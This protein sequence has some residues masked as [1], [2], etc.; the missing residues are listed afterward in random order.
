MVLTN[1]SRHWGDKLETLGSLLDKF[2]INKIRLDKYIAQPDRE[3]SKLASIEGVSVSLG[4]EIDEY[5]SQALTGE[6]PLEEPKNKLYNANYYEEQKFVSMSDVIDK[7]F[8]ANLTLW[9]LEDQRR[10][11]SFP[12]DVRLKICD[13]V[14]VVNGLRNNCMDEIN[15]ILSELINSKNP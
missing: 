7:L 15:K 2:A 3:V 5:L 14:S 8:G 1:Y 12:D 6:I 11:K 13:E 10:D 9:N 4:R